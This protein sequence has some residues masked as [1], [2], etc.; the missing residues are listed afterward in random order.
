M[1]V[2]GGQ[3]LAVEV[4]GIQQSTLDAGYLTLNLS[5]FCLTSFAIWIS[6]FDVPNIQTFITSSYIKNEYRTS[7][8]LAVIS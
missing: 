8:C 7:S 2:N 6:E 3:T 4:H 5:N 1:E